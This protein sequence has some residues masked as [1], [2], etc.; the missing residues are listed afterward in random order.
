[1]EK[2][3]IK[4]A[5]N[6]WTSF[7]NDSRYNWNNDLNPGGSGQDCDCVLNMIWFPWRPEAPLEGEECSGVLW[8]L[9]VE[10]P[11]GAWGFA[12]GPSSAEAAV[13]KV[14]GGSWK[15]ASQPVSSA[16]SQGCSTFTRS[17]RPNWGWED[18]PHTDI[19]S[20]FFFLNNHLK[21]LALCSLSYLFD[22]TIWNRHFCVGK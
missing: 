22:L 9:Q 6:F 12:D 15:P 2:P 17:C 16:N 20:F 14:T 8:S 11:V 3:K 18:Q 5:W 7:L 13:V 21:S 1:M 10:L 19:S 4:D